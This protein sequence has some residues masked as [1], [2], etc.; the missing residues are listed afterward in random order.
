MFDSFI[1][2]KVSVQG[3]FKD[4]FKTESIKTEFRKTL[5]LLHTDSS[6]SILSYHHRSSQLN[7][8][9]RVLIHLLPCRVIPLLGRAGHWDVFSLKYKPS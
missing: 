9:E 7:Y 4:L 1:L 8:C 5:K 2:K 6:A 3:K